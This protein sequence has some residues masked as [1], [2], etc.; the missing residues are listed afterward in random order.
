MKNTASKIVKKT[1]E[2][3]PYLTQPVELYELENGHTIVIVKK[4]SELVNIST[5]VKTGSINEDDKINGISHF[6]EHLMFKGTSKHPAGEFDRTLES[7]GAIVNAATW[8]DYT[9]YYVTLPKGENN[10]YFYEALDLH[11]DMM[12]DPI[13][14]EEEIG[15]QF[16]FSNPEVKEKRERYVVIEEIRMRDDQPWTKVYNEVNNL[17]YTS[18]PYKRDV[19]GTGEIIS[20]VPRQTI[21]DYYKTWYTPENMFTIV[22]GDV[23]SAETVDLIREKFIF[24]DITKSPVVKHP[25][26]K[27]Q[28]EQ[29]YIEINGNVNTGFTIFGFNG[30]QASNSKDSIAL[31]VISI[32][33]GEGKSC[34]LVQ[35]LIEKPENPIFNIVGTEQYKFKDGNTF[36]IQANFMPNSKEQ[37]I[38]LLKEELET[39]LNNPITS[40]EFEKAMKKLKVRF[41]EEAE[42]VSEIGESI[43]YFL[44]VCDGNLAGYTDYL[45]T[46]NSLTIKDI[47]QVAS[48]YLSLNK[49]NISVLMPE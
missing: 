42:T 3:L 15:P 33:L 39:I 7:K 23:D 24:K 9:F 44:V 32:I 47:Q 36:F 4:D 5:W 31:D 28:T 17:M 35:N 45:K 13:I 10:K 40:D 12:I 19:I 29:K 30:P 8:K 11:A 2:E 26:E 41:A 22:V 38:K 16:D 48:K 14:P 37:A 34:R 6:L 49:A 21:M 1:L 25:L 27:E 18:H 20:S 46:L 43:G